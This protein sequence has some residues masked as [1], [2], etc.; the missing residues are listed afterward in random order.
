MRSQEVMDMAQCNQQLRILRLRRRSI[1]I[2][3]PRQR[4][5]SA[6]TIGRTQ[7]APAMPVKVTTR[8]GTRS[9]KKT[10]PVRE[11]PP[12]HQELTPGRK[13]P[14]TA[15]EPTHDEIEIIVTSSPVA[16]RPQSS[17]IISRSMRRR[18]SNFKVVAKEGIENEPETIVVRTDQPSTSQTIPLSPLVQLPPKP[19]TFDTPSK[20]LR[21]DLS[22]IAERTE[23]SKTIDKTLTLTATQISA[24]REIVNDVST[25][26]DELEKTNE[27]LDASRNKW[28]HI[29]REE[30]EKMSDDIQGDIDATI[31]KISLLQRSKFKQYLGLI[32]KC[33]YGELDGGKPVLTGDLVGYWS[34]VS[35]QLDQIEDSFE[36]LSKLQANQWTAMEPQAVPVRKPLAAKKKKTKAA[37][38]LTSEA[39]K[40]RQDAARARMLA[41]KQA[42]R[43]KM[44]AQSNA[45]NNAEEPEEN[46]ENKKPED[47]LMF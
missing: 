37:K 22:T 20:R 17:S 45:Q 44:N 12:I 6:P 21:H 9:T 35:M 31:G 1:K 38:Q 40:K 24:I 29:L 26:E 34:I 15:R 14:S 33:K 5:V 42:M 4:S 8:R 46:Q 19:S 41:V 36:G 7:H 10:N 18:S 28:R 25:F 30:Q 3:A 23:A 32:D 13:R 39:A 47:V 43:D 11:K 2:K 27:K 16:L